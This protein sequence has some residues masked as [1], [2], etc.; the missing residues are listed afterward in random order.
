MVIPELML[1]TVISILKEKL[2]NLPL[3]ISQEKVITLPP[4][5]Q[6]EGNITFIDNG[7]MVVVSIT[8]V[9]SPGQ[10]LFI[11]TRKA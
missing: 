5:T 11:T 7:S 3:S 2:K 10:H 8:P 4:G 9:G 1:I 6:V